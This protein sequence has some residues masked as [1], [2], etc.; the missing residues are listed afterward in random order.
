VFVV[1]DSFLIEVPIELEMED[2]V[3]RLKEV[4]HFKHKGEEQVFNFEIKEG[5]SWGDLM[6]A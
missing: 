3:D 1:F 4:S 5:Y 6:D 2:Y